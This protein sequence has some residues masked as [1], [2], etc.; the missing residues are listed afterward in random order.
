MLYFTVWQLSKPSCSSCSTIDETSDRLSDWTDI[1]HNVSHYNPNLS[2]SLTWN[3][4]NEVFKRPWSRSASHRNSTPSILNSSTESFG[5]YHSH[6]SFD[7]DILSFSES[8]SPSKFHLSDHLIASYASSH[9]NSSGSMDPPLSKKARISFH[10]ESSISG[11]NNSSNISEIYKLNGTT[12][13]CFYP[14]ATSTPFVSPP[15]PRFVQKPDAK[16]VATCDNRRPFFR[17]ED[18][19]AVYYLISKYL[20]TNNPNEVEKAQ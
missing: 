11:K 18:E 20:T 17:S 10:T 5:N 2:N 6:A 16:V 15:D 12:S 8:S 13:P 4:S 9:S 1:V 14:K 3:S 19:E 7:C